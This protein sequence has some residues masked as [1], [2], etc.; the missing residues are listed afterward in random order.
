MFAFKHRVGG[1]GTL[2]TLP[3]DRERAEVLY[4]CTTP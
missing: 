2:D 3:P 1:F 4:H